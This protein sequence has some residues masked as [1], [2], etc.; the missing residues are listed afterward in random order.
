VTISATA[1]GSLK[2]KATYSGDL[3]NLKSS[4][5]RVLTVD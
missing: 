5:T 1:T 3:N 2:I 4:K